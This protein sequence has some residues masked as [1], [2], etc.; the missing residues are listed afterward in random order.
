MLTEIALATGIPYFIITIATAAFCYA[1]DDVGPDDPE[2]ILSE[3]AEAI[4]Y[5]FLGLEWP[6]LLLRGLWMLGCWIG[7]SYANYRQWRRGIP[8]ARVVK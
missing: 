2:N 6:W 5:V 3:G 7:V 4:W 8:K 1:A